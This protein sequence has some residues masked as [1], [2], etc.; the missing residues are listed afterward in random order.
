LKKPS[1]FATEPL[2]ATPIPRAIPVAEPIASAPTHVPEAAVPPSMGHVVAGAVGLGELAQPSAGPAP[3]AGTPAAATPAAPTALTPEQ[4]HAQTQQGIEALKQGK[5]IIRPGQKGAEVTLLQKQLHEMG[6]HVK[7]TGV[8]DAA[9]TGYIKALQD[10]GGLGSDGIVGPKTLE[11]LQKLDQLPEK[12]KP[13]D[14]ADKVDHMPDDPAM[15][16]VLMFNR[17]RVANAKEDLSANQQADM[18]AFLKNWE[19]NKARYDAVA[20]KA[21]IPTKL[22]ASLHWR[23]STGDFGTYLHQGDPLGEE[24]VNEP[25]PSQVYD[26]WEPA[27]QDALSQKKR[28]QNA[29]K[30]D[31]ATTDEATLVSYA[32][33]YNGLGYHNKGHVSPYAFSGTDQ[34]KGGKYIRDHVYSETAKDEQLGVLSM[35]RAIDKHDADAAAK[36]AKALQDQKPAPPVP[37]PAPETTPGHQFAQ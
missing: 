11:Q 23:E 30:I 20:Q 26:T 35:L 15:A 25:K 34:Y 16:A 5:H 13:G 37:P 4:E 6:M 31:S 21:G 36:A 19:K 1:P 24:A 10:G 2:R 9:T 17:T 8:Y 7:V 3:A 28:I 33:R 18:K 14:D 32:E 22:V 29:Y 27:A 12:P